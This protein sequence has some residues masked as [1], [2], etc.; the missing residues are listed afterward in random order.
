MSFSDYIVSMK[1]LK[2]FMPPTYIEPY[3]ESTDPQEHMDTFKSRMTFAA[4]S[5]LVKCRTFL[6]TLKKA[7]FK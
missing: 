2:D 3:D 6:I 7:A 5:D 4:A 1:L